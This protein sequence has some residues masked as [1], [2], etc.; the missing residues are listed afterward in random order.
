MQA[1]SSPSLETDCVGCWPHSLLR[2]ADLVAQQAPAAPASR[3]LHQSGRRL[4]EAPLFR[5]YYNSDGGLLA[6]RRVR[7]WQAVADKSLH[8]LYLQGPC[9]GRTRNLSG[10]GP[11]G[12]RF[13]S[14]PSD[15]LLSG[16]NPRKSCRA[17]PKCCAF[18]LGSSLTMIPLSGTR[19]H[20]GCATRV[21]PANS[22]TL[23]TRR[24]FY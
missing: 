5:L 6:A 13:E 2:N 22:S 24:L 14:Y 11:E 10:L 7:G 20:T 18:V 17:P 12:H 16:E 3:I 19:T 23:L 4:I 21:P 15:H 9:E 1:L 8:A